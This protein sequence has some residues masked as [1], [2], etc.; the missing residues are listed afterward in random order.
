[1][2]MDRFPDELILPIISSSEQRDLHALCLTSQR[3]R[4]I[5]QELLYRAPSVR[6]APAEYPQLSTHSRIWPLF[7]TLLRRPDL[8]KHVKRLELSPQ[9]RDVAINSDIIINMPVEAI[10]AISTISFSECSLVGLLLG[11]VPNLEE[12]WVEILKDYDEG[13]PWHR[14]DFR[15]FAWDAMSQ[16]FGP[17]KVEHH[18]PD[19]L[20]SP[21]L[22]NLRLLE[23]YGR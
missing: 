21:G 3:L 18:L 11:L 8:A 17:T 2:T 6:E 10:K 7:R 1:M 12:L 15:R 22:Q 16:F 9:V 4:R 14:T 23:F 19:F 5:S 20:Q 13:H